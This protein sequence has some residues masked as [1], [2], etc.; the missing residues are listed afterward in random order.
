VLKFTTSKSVLG[1]LE[2][3][4]AD[5]SLSENPLDLV[6]LI[7]GALAVVFGLASLVLAIDAVRRRYPGIVT[8]FGVLAVVFGVLVV[9]AGFVAIAL[10]VLH[11]AVASTN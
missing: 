3:Q 5:G 1:G 6:W 11:W 9:A 7:A 10:L 2:K 4:L 8:V